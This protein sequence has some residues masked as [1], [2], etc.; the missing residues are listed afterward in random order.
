MNFLAQYGIY[1]VEGLIETIYSR[2]KTYYDYPKTVFEV[3]NGYITF[4]ASDLDWLCEKS[5]EP[6]FWKF[7]RK[8]AKYGLDFRGPY[9]SVKI[10][11]LF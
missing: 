4:N 11:S 2:L 1:D 7:L 10:S 5:E 9:Y 3:G 8:N 6:E